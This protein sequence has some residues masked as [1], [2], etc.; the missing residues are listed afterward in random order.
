MKS[1]ELIKMKLSNSGIR[2]NHIAE[3]LHISKSTF[4]GLLKRSL[5]ID[6]FLKIC[7]IANFDEDEILDEYKILNDL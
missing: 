2:Q 1:G 6:L 5:T 7:K 3:Q 4:S